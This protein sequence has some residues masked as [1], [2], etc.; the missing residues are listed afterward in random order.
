MHDSFGIVIFVLDRGSRPDAYGTCT[1]A[2]QCCRVL[3]Y[4]ARCP[5][6][7]GEVNPLLFVNGSLVVV[8]KGLVRVV[9]D[10]T[11]SKSTVYRGPPYRYRYR[12][13]HSGCSAGKSSVSYPSIYYCPSSYPPAN[14]SIYSL[15][16]CSGIKMSDC[17]SYQYPGWGEWAR[18]NLSFTQAI[19]VGDRIHCSGQGPIY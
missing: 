6:G 18:E 8:V 14:L 2:R 16:Q 17:K 3:H 13:R 5:W 12:Y 7:K 10:K 15:H 9:A 11:S 4:K 1:A 19:R